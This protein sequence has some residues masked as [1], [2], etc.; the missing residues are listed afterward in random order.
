MKRSVANARGSLWPA[1][2][3]HRRPHSVPPQSRE[4]GG[5]RAQLPL[6]TPPAS[7]AGC[8]ALPSRLGVLR[9]GVQQTLGHFPGGGVHSDPG[10]RILAQS[11]KPAAAPECVVRVPCPPRRPRA[12]APLVST[13][14]SPVKGVHPRSGSPAPAT[15]A[16]VHARSQADADAASRPSGKL[17]RSLCSFLTY[18][19]NH[20]ISVPSQ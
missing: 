7:M 18:G 15:G 4:W 3:S 20:F 12:T 14:G 19:N 10:T 5:R 13:A 2:E 16:G 17:S 8:S 11:R 9:F 6:R 1:A